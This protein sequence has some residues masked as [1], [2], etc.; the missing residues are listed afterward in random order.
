MLCTSLAWN[1]KAWLALSVPVAAGK[2]EAKQQAEKHKL[3][4][5]EFRT[6][7]NSWLRIPCQVLRTGRQLVCRVL[8]WNE[9][10]ITFFRLAQ[11]LSQPL[12]C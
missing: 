8:A 3:L 2:E 9:W 10:Q 4:R 5:L 1:L 11:A 7:V 12:R 6:F